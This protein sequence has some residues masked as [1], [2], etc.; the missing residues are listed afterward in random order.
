MDE[1][2]KKLPRAF[3]AITERLTEDFKA[4]QVYLVGGAV[5][6]LI[7]KRDTKDYDLVIRGLNA[8]QLEGWLQD[9]GQVSLVGRSFGI[10]KWQPAGWSG[11]AIDVA[12]PRTEH[13]EL[14]TGQ[15]RDFAIQS[16]PEL[17]IEDDLSRRDFTINAMALDLKTGQLIDPT[18]GQFDLKNKLI[19]AV[20]KPAKRFSEDLSR[21]LR[22]LRQA[23]QLNFDIEPSTLA[24]AKNLSKKAAAGK[25]QAD[26][27]VPREIVAR[28]L[29]K[30]LVAA[31]AAAI[32]LF[33]KTGFLTEF[34]PEVA[35]MKSVPQPPEFHSEGDVYKH[36]LLALRTFT[37][38][39]WKIF[40]DQAKPSLSVIVA[41][42]LHDIG[43][44]LTIKTPAQHG[45]D[46]I[47]TDGHDTAGAKL[48][49]DICQRLKLTS[50]VDAERGGVNVALVV[51]L[52]E[53]HMLLVHGLPQLLKP[54]T[55][56]RYF[57]KDEI[58][59]Q[60][61]QQTIFA[62]AMASYPKNGKPSASRLADLRLRLEGIKRELGGRKL[63]PLV[64]GNDIMR[65][66]KLK[67]GPPIGR[68]LK[69]AEEAQLNGLI[70]TKAQ[71]KK[72]LQDK[73]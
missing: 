68:L 42:L 19:R 61:L 14:G 48:I 57:L 44:P 28:E 49:P 72:F 27:L 60:A 30:A 65:L 8:H 22:C 52:V 25:Y 9:R 51:W 67:P 29:L 11:E 56:Y 34:L 12:L 38:P 20:G 31:P 43:K 33:E 17:P 40:F 16:D 3:I 70:S 26:W 41:T 71:A 23:C 39:A 59:G 63:V 35:A 73:I 24:A 5:R 50:Y 45:T 13:A 32:S 69:L 6:D 10:F 18:D 36:T 64:T 7:L 58:W 46:R 4:S 2:L 47:R 1:L 15:Y 62:D 21:T 55:I 66:F 54:S 37:T 53:N